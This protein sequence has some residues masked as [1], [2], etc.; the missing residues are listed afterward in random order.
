VPGGDALC[1]L[2]ALNKT[3]GQ[4]TVMSMAFDQNFRILRSIIPDPH[5]PEVDITTDFKIF[6]PYLHVSEV[7]KDLIVSHT[8]VGPLFVSEDGVIP[9][10]GERPQDIEQLVK[11]MSREKGSLSRM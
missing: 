10:R 6:A 7:F 11:W 9:L 1:L 4:V 3:S 5:N 2:R 8:D